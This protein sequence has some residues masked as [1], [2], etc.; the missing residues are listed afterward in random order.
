MSGRPVRLALAGDGFRAGLHLDLAA[1]VPHLLEVTGVLVRTP[2]AAERLTARRGVRATTDPGEL[3]RARPDLVLTALPAAAG[4]ALAVELV[5]RGAAVVAETPPAADLAGLRAL[6]AALGPGGRVQVAEQYPW[7]PHHAARREVVRR[8]LLGEV[9]SVQVSSTQLHHATALVRD[10]LDLAADPVR[11]VASA[12]T[13]PLANPVARPG[14]TDDDAPAPRTTT[15]ATLDVGDGRSALYDFT[16]TQTRNPLR[17]RR[18]VVRGSLGELVDDR[19]VRLAGPRTVLTSTVERRETGRHQDVQGLDLDQLSLE[20][21]V[22][23][24]NPFAGARLMDEEIAV[25]S[26]LVAAG[27][28]A[29]GE[30]PPPY[31]LAQAAQDQLL[32]LAIDASVA[33]GGPVTTTVEPWARAL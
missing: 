20:G 17:T 24:R 7:S 10:L 1:R 28:W 22:L 31:P 6:W 3:L 12:T 29:R 2:G 9:T 30:G 4:A 23:F 27:S 14:W 15:L 13:A 8:G 19:V 33:S 5:G 16:D 21:G 26:L 25:L 32:G 18:I 11:V